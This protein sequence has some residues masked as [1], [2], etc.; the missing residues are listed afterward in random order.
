MDATQAHRFYEE[1]LSTIYVRGQLEHLADYY[2]PE[3]AIHPPIPGLP[4]GIVGMELAMR[5]FLS[6]FS[7]IS[8]H[9]EDFASEGGDT[10]RCRVRVETT[11][12]GEFMGLAATGRRVEIVAEHRFRLNGSRIAESWSRAD[13]THVQRELSASSQA[14]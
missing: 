10:F 2:L 11:H 6:S 13:F 8:L 12:S 3:V 9:M 4:A 7:S 1:C 5:G 14:A